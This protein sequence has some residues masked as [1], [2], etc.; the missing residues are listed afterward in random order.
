MSGFRDS[1][2]KA[3][4]SLPDKASVSGR[5]FKSTVTELA[6]LL[7][8]MN[9][10]IVQLERQKAIMYRGIWTQG[11]YKQGD[12]VTDRGTIWHCECD[13]ESRPG[14]DGSWRMMVKNQK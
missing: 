7:E 6:G 10:R 4:S 2:Q 1:I 5:L 9:A 11:E 14:A 3:L 12:I 13:T 8:S